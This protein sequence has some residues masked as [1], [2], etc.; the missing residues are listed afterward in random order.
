MPTESCLRPWSR[1]MPIHRCE[2]VFTTNLNL[3]IAQ[4]TY[5]NHLLSL[6]QSADMTHVTHVRVHVLGSMISDPLSMFQSFQCDV[7]KVA[8]DGMLRLA[9]ASRMHCCGNPRSFKVYRDDSD[10]VYENHALDAAAG[11]SQMHSKRAVAIAPI[12]MYSQRMRH[13]VHV[14]DQPVLAT[15]WSRGGLAYDEFPS[16]VSRLRDVRYVRQ[17][18]FSIHHNVT[19]IFEV[20]RSNDTRD[21]HHQVYAEYVREDADVHQTMLAERRL[22]CALADI[23]LRSLPAQ[24]LTPPQTFVVLGE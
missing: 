1:G 14:Q 8:F 16:C 11:A 5:V 15:H 9:A 7:G 17:M 12:R 20:S 22:L 24:P 3:C 18:L 4:K 13:C 23:G 10:R 6:G 2:K 21:V 19:L